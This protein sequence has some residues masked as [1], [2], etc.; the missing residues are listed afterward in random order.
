MLGR[1]AEAERVLR[2]V[3]ASAV[4]RRPSPN[5]VADRARLFLGRAL[6]DEGRV[7][8]AEPLLLSVVGARGHTLSIASYR[9]AISSLVELYRV[10]GRPAD[11]A[12]YVAISRR[13]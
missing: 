12:Q 10:E 5:P 1:S 4:A 3:L 13:P 6:L 9:L 7:T 11:A 2:D 8:E